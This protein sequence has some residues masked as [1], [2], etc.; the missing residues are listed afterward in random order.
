MQEITTEHIEFFKPAKQGFFEHQQDPLSKCPCL[1]VGQIKWPI[2][3]YSHLFFLVHDRAGEYHWFPGNKMSFH[4]DEP[5]AVD[6][7]SPKQKASWFRFLYNGYEPDNIIQ[8]TG[9]L[10]RDGTKYVVFQMSG[11]L[12]F[13]DGD[14]F[15]SICRTEDQKFLWRKDDITG[16]ADSFIKAWENMPAYVTDPDD[17]EESPIFSNNLPLRDSV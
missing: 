8:L 2:A 6:F 4:F 11:R 14:F 10:T 17:D 12:V 15:V 7:L 1:V 9:E 16:I 5:R 3:P 13:K